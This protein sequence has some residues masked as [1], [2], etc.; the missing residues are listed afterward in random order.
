[1]GCGTQGQRRGRCGRAMPD[2][3]IAGVGRIAPPFFDDMRA[4]GVVGTTQAGSAHPGLDT[5]E[6]PIGPEGAARAG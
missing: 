5:V 4:T 3:P 6:L 2:I 1:M